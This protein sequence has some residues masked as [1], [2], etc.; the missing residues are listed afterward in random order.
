MLNSFKE[1]LIWQKSYS[2]TKDVYRATKDLPTAER[3]SLSDQIHR[4]S[5]SIPSN[6]A[7][8]YGRGSKKDYVKFLRIAY[9]STL[10]LETQ[11]LL[12]KDL[13]NLDTRSAIDSLA[14]VQKMLY[15]MIK[16]LNPEP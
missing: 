8:G 4:S 9:G 10:E 14:E 1:L 3:F 11:L 5:V 16:K 12:V 6:I 2:L 7:E 15:V 13:Y